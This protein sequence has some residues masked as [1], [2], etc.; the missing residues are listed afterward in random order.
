MPTT[1]N[2]Q[3][4]PESNIQPICTG[5]TQPQTE[6]EPIQFVFLFPLS[7]QDQLTSYTSS[8]SLQT[9]FDE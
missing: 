4:Q 1:K 3:M 2:Q 8:N 6:W 9:T 7:N 5:D